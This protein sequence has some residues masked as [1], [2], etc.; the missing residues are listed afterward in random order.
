MSKMMRIETSEST[1]RFYH[2]IYKQYKFHYTARARYIWKVIRNTAGPLDYLTDCKRTQ[3]QQ[4]FIK[5]IKRAKELRDLQI[6]GGTAMDVEI[7]RIALRL[8]AQRYNNIY[9]KLSKENENA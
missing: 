3:A 1:L 7:K 2:V 9:G 6:Y 4:E 5:V 8:S